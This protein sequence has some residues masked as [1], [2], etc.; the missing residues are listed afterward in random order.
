[1]PL[2]LRRSPVIQVTG[3][4]NRRLGVEQRL[5]VT[6]IVVIIN[7]LAHDRKKK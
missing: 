7:S 1:M 3:V 5:Q 2:A 4:S 6:A